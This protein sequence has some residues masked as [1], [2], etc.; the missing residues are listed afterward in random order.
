MQE[1]ARSFHASTDSVYGPRSWS[2]QPIRLPVDDR[3]SLERD[4]DGIGQTHDL[5]QV[6]V[7][8]LPNW[9][10]REKGTSH[11]GGVDAK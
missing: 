7:A 4:I 8:A 3:A 9:R 2:G 11:I 6:A 1:T 10:R 5:N